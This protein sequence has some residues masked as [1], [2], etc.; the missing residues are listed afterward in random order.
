M[1]RQQQE[2]ITILTINFEVQFYD[3]WC[4]LQVRACCPLGK[5][6]FSSKEETGT[7][8]IAE[9]DTE[10]EPR[11]GEVYLKYVNTNCKYITYHLQSN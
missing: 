7:L 11:G 8:P 3:R 10:H 4:K 9:R 2:K 1:R 6:P 5:T